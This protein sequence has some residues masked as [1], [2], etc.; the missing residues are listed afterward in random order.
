MVRKRVVHSIALILFLVGCT[1]L[2]NAPSMDGKE[3]ETDKGRVAPNAPKTPQPKEEAAITSR[4]GNRIGERPL[5]PSI[6]PQTA[7][8]PCAT[9]TM[10]LRGASSHGNTA[11]I[12]SAPSNQNVRSALI[13]VAHQKNWPGPLNFC[14]DGWRCLLV[15]AYMLRSP[16]SKVY[17]VRG[18]QLE[19]DA[20][21][22][23]IWG[24][25]I[26]END[27][28]DYVTFVHGGSQYIKKK[29][30]SEEQLKGKLRMVYSEA[31]GG[32]HGE[33]A[34]EKFNAVAAAG[35]SVRANDISAS[36]FFSTAF[37]WAWSG[38]ETLKNSIQYASD[39]GNWRLRTRIGFFIAQ[40]AA[41]YKTP[42]SAIEQSRM[43]Y[44]QWEHLTADQVT[45]NTRIPGITEN[46]GNIEKR[47]VA[48]TTAAPKTE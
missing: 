25:A 1:G 43:C 17:C 3:Q 11:P 27:Q 2:S 45:I 31:C 33:L 42:E 6:N 38:G 12:H 21:M 48:T 46:R 22:K 16:Y 37:L 34:L 14:W 30:A 23:G 4:E 8:S 19:D 26:A 41:G 47:E 10:R 36:P 15:K 20:L 28:I 39:C 5:A 35:H 24:K 29:W 7:Q 32:G 13:Y 9:D 18:T 40:L 44:A